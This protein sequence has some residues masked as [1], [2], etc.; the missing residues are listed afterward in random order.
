M[1]RHYFPRSRLKPVVW[2]GSL[3]V[4]SATA[5][6]RYEAGKHYPTDLLTGAAFGSLVGWGIPKLHQIK[7]RSELGRRLDVQPWS[8]G[9][10][11]GIYV[12]L[13]VF[14]R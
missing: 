7:N 12:R 8:S 2:I 13:P 4:A 11:S 10:A 9:V 6:L 1:F 5:V 14:S 3:G